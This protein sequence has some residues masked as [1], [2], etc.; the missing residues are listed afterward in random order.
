MPHR[1][2]K[3]ADTGAIDGGRRKDSGAANYNAKVIYTLVDDNFFK[4]SRAAKSTIAIRI[5]LF[6]TTAGVYDVVLRDRRV[7]TV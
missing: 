5:Y 1:A 3:G 2:T 4:Y 6:P 7:V